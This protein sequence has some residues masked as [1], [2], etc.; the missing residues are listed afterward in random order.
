M[1]GKHE[2]PGHL[3]SGYA[4]GLAT[5]DDS[6][7]YAMNVGRVYERS[8]SSGSALSRNISKVTRAQVL[9]RIGCTCQMCGLAAGDPDPFGGNRTVRLT[10]GHI[11]DKSKGGDDSAHN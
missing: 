2:Q 4:L 10:M 3:A 9:E 8:V 7:C 5:Q 6:G 1:F 11:V